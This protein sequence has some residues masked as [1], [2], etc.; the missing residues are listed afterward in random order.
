[1]RKITDKVVHAARESLGEKLDK[2]ILFGSYARGDY[3]EESDVDIFVLADVPLEE[4]H[5]EYKRISR[6]SGFLSL[7]F[8]VLIS[9]HVASCD[10]F[11]RF[12]RVEPFYTNVMN[13]GVILSA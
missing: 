2:V 3:T 6:L 7:D 12:L 10:N 9:I 4:C 5:D 11:Y 8:N 13:E 1:L